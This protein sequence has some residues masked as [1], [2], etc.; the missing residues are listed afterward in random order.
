LT[1]IA[2]IWQNLGHMM[3]RTLDAITV[4]GLCCRGAEP[5]IEASP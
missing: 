3:G 2:W 1:A 4:A 5:G